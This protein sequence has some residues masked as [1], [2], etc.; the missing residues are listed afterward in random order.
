MSP[1]EQLYIVQEATLP[2]LKN[3]DTIKA[4]SAANTFGNIGDRDDGEE[5]N[6]IVNGEDNGG[7]EVPQDGENNSHNQEE[8]NSVPSP[9]PSPRNLLV[10]SKSVKIEGKKLSN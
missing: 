5:S 4:V 8:D 7:Q 2:C 1:P 10:S 9:P 6:T 3:L